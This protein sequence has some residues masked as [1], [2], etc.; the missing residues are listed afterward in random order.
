MAVILIHTTTRVL[1]FSHYDLK[2]YPFTLLLNQ[3]ARFAVPM[4]FLISGFVLELSYSENFISFIKKRFSRI[5]IPYIFW[6]AFYYFFVY[7]VH[8]TN[9]F[10]SIL[11]GSSS[12]QLYFIP[13]LLILYIIF[14]V[15][16]FLYKYLSKW[17]VLIILGM[18][19]VWIL[20]QDY[21][22]R[23]LPFPFPI[24]V[25]LFN[26]YIFILGM[27]GAHNRLKI[28]NVLKETWLF[29]AIGSIIAA[30]FIYNQGLSIYYKTYNIN[31]FYSQWRP[32]VLIYSILVSG[33]LLYIYSKRKQN[34]YSIKKLSSYSLFVFFV[35]VLFIEIIWK[36]FGAE[37][38]LLTK[39][40]WQWKT[41]FDLGFFGV[42]TYISFFAAYMAHKIPRLNRIVG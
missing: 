11:T 41:I 38:H 39:D 37:L 1:E 19:Q 15:L 30:Q 2:D 26:F 5:F 35:H 20:K 31:S 40:N 13:S 34:H 21:F 42:V 8:S 24:S 4:F 33:V 32:G 29:I 12:Y 3:I 23:S 6:S 7:K 22:I 18:L 17:W 9:F 27:V 16:H 10:E 28:K 36:Y 25:A 14:P